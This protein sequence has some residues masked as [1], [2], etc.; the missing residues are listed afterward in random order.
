MAV[1]DTV[2]NFKRWRDN[3][4]AWRRG[5]GLLFPNFYAWR[6]GQLSTWNYLSQFILFNIFIKPK[7]ETQKIKVRIPSTYA[8][9]MQQI[10]PEK[11]SSD[12]D[13]APEIEPH[14]NN[15]EEPEITTP[16]NDSQPPSGK[17]QTP[18]P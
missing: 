11:L 17:R 13:E 1:F 18:Q 12:G 7:D 4:L 15:I 3:F 5:E 10:S 2:E 14:Q 16:I 8:A 9:L 6:T